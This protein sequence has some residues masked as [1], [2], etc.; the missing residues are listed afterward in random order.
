MSEKS[1]DAP[2]QGPYPAVHIITKLELG[3]AQENTLFTVGHLDR[4]TF[5]PYLLHGPGGLLDEE[6]HSLPGVTAGCIKHLV[7]EPRPLSDFLALVGIC[8]R[9]R[10]I[11]RLHKAPLIVHTHSS[12][13]GILGRWAARLAGADVIIHSIHGFGFNPR[14]NALSRWFFIF[15]ERMTAGI[16]TAFIAVSKANISEGV[17][18]RIFKPE[19]AT[20][21]RSG[22][23]IDDFSSPARNPG[24]V[25]RELGIPDNAPVVGMIACFKPQKSPEDFIRIAGIVAGK[26]PK[27]RFLVIGDGVLR[28]RVEAEVERLGLSDRVV[29]TGWRRDIPDLLHAL[30][31]LVLTSRWEGLPR[32]C[33]QAMAAGKPVVA[34]AVDGTPEAVADGE[35]GFL[36]EPGDLGSMA[37]SVMA[38][39]SDPGMARQFGEEGSRRVAE[40]DAGVMVRRQEDLYQRLLEAKSGPDASS[41]AKIS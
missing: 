16:T 13:A 39:L 38:L 31:V 12:K 33:P 19:A 32:V 24:D 27:T 6:A 25:R 14:Q 8:R 5:R 10:K 15:L 22:I 7:R 28:G 4:T 30:D 23:V 18:L 20:L 21:I 36:A 9:I 11:K 35:T 17:R 2:V 41:G 3:G 1:P 29:L 26:M 34:T 37:E 40:F